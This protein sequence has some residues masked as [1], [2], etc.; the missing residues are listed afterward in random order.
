MKFKKDL[1][2]KLS[3]REI[4]LEN[5]DKELTKEIV[6]EAFPEDVDLPSGN[7]TFYYKSC[8]G[9]WEWTCSNGSP[10]ERKYIVKATDFVQKDFVLGERILVKDEKHKY[11]SERI[12]LFR[13]DD[14]YHCV[15][16]LQEHKYN[17]NQYYAV[18]SWMEAKKCKDKLEVTVELN[19]K[20]VHPSKISKETW[21]NLRET[22]KG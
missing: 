21:E 18:D 12:F 19:G 1:I 9:N 11:W 14:L 10:L 7:S 4:V 5:N 22:S 8:S 3:K 20:K 15:A 16:G 13:K 17:K 6:R 2:E